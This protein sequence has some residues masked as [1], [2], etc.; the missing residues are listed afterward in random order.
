MYFRLCGKTESITPLPILRGIKK[1]GNPIYP[2]SGFQDDRIIPSSGSSILIPDDV[3][4]MLKKTAGVTVKDDINNNIYP[5]PL[6]A[7][8]KFD[9]EVGRIRQNL[10]FGENGLEFFVC[11]DQILKGAALNAVQ[12]SELVA[13]QRFTE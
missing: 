5:M 6:T 9:V 13:K 12:I 7:S 8:E 4:K 11:G 10:V 1:F 2:C 3:R